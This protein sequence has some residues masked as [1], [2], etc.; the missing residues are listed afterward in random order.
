[1]S[2]HTNSRREFLRDGLAAA[3]LGGL[4]VSL[5]SCS[6]SSAVLPDARG[7]DLGARDRRPPDR[8]D[9]PRPDWQAVDA[10]A[11]K[12]PRTTVRERVQGVLPTQKQPDSVKKLWGVTHLVPG[13]PHL[14][15]DTLG[16]DETAGT[17]SG[18]AAS[19][20]YL[21]QI[22]DVHVVDEESP[23]RTLN[24]DKLLDPVWR[25]QEAHSCQ[26]LD[27]MVR[28]VSALHALRAMD[29]V[30]VTGDC[31]DNNQRNELTWF[32]NVLQGGSLWPNSG[33]HEDPAP[34]PNNDPHDAMVAAGLGAIPWYV[35]MGNH[36]GLIQGN[37]I[38]AP[39]L[40]YALLTGDPTRGSIGAIDLGRVNPPACNPIPADEAAQP[41]RCIPTS[42]GA[43]KSGS[44]P[45]DKERVHLPR[46]EWTSLVQGAGGL[47]A[48]HGL[49][50]ATSDGDYVVEPV[51]GLPLRL[52]AM[53]TCA[54]AGAEGVLGSGRIDGFLTTALQKAQ[55]DDM[56]V[57]VTTHHPS[58]AIV[59]TGSRLRQTLNSFPNV[60]LHLVGHDHE[61]RV[62][63][64]PGA[65]PQNGYWEVQ[66]CSLCEWPQQ[67]R[68]V[69]LVDRRDGTAELW[70]TLI[71]F[72]TS[73]QPLGSIV[74]GARFLA[75]REIHGGARGGGL[76]M[77]G[78]EGDRNV[79]LPVALSTAM[80]AKLA[81][82]AGHA[83]ESK[84]FV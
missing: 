8:G 63:A 52:I 53:N 51:A 4:G 37:L 76:A 21:T 44:L 79:I 82:I 9:L 31:I 32:L 5:L 58:D 62:L 7:R 80:R 67:A 83:I 34:G 3:G 47:P 69:E 55:D 39:L 56:L 6:G 70:L 20:L 84:L 30:L 29:L 17:P 64:R 2:R 65:G 78:A 10:A 35:V 16:V 81:A 11:A 77:E 23:A 71:D 14:R 41:Q 43:L 42:P 40:G 15:L 24:L 74:E 59:L 26:V 19:L 75:L 73:H 28:Q 27:A 13:D 12:R 68:L 66:T 72:D 25:A 38:R 48:G 60:V 61:N 1:M 46:D 54:S 45:P 36:D 33:T 18:P 22:T 49:A 57:I 50:G